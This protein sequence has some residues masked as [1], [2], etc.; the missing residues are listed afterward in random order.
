MG[1][2]PG[3]NPIVF[4]IPIV[5]TELWFCLASKWVAIC[6]R[7]AAVVFAAELLS[8]TRWYGER[9]AYEMIKTS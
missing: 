2:R 6:S 4:P 5:P 7:I 9:G 8:D 1:H 3:L